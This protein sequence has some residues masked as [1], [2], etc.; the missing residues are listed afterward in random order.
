MVHESQ[1]PE[2]NPTNGGP[3][4]VPLMKVFS[5]LPEPAKKDLAVFANFSSK[6]RA[7]HASKLLSFYCHG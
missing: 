1:L 6:L 2:P 5:T 3:A 4:K 7:G